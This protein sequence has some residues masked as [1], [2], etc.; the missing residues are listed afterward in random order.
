MVYSTCSISPEENE[1]VVNFLL[2]NYDASI[3]LGQQARRLVETRYSW[4]VFAKQYLAFYRTVLKNPQ[5]RNEQPIPVENDPFWLQETIEKG[6][7]AN[8]Q[9]DPDNI[10]LLGY[11]KKVVVPIHDVDM[12]TKLTQFLKHR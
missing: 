12:T 2:E 7:F 10:Y 1:E 6:R 5:R 9:G 11:G 8:N 4:N 3:R